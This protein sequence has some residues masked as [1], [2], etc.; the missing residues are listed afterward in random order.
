MFLS[1]EWADQYQLRNTIYPAYLAAP[2][3]LLKQFSLDYQSIVLVQPYLTHCLLVIM[4]DIF[5]WKSAKKYV[6]D[7]AARIT[8]LLCLV[9]RTQNEFI[10][11]CFTNSLE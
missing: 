10:P 1:W 11:K 5:L 6:G 4:G 8:M 7:N 2:L 3:Y 9:S